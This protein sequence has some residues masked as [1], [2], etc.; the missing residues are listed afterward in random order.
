[1]C[2]I[3]GCSISQLTSQEVQSLSQRFIEALHHRGPD[4]NGFWQE[5]DNL[6][7]THNRLAILDLSEHGRQP[8]LAESGRYVITFNGEIYNFSRLKSDLEDLGNTFKGRSDTEVILALVDAYGIEQTLC[9]IDGMFAFALYDRE[10][11][12]ITIARD[13][14][15]EKPLFYGWVD[16]RFV[17]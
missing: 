9:M 2:G 3:A 17:F 8:M 5:N 13:R 15:G 4:G 11:E 14:M 10:R 7:L 6:L 12:E 16:G 1:M